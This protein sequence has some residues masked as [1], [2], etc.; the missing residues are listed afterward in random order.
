MLY[1]WPLYDCCLLV[2]LLTVYFVIQ[3]L[4]PEEVS[5]CLIE[6]SFSFDI[7]SDVI[8]VLLFVFDKYFVLLLLREVSK[9]LWVTA[10]KYRVYDWPTITWLNVV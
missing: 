5:Q 9:F 10:S 7:K 1:K 6:C 4:W 3:L 8:K 2:K